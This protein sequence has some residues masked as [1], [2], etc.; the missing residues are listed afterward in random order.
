MSLFDLPPKPVSLPPE[1]MRFDGPDYD[2]AVDNPRLSAQLLRVFTLMSDGRWRTL[3]E[4][5]DSTGDPAASVSAQLR[6]LRKARFGGHTVEKRS[7]G[8]REKG[9][10][11]YRMEG[12]C[13]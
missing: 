4:I 10:Y 11:E 2:A 9:L 5:A 1:A 12:K 6:H 7:T 13:Q 8:K 3:Q